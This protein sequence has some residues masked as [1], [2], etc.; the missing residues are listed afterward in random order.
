MITTPVA[1][2]IPE[3]PGAHVA[4]SGTFFVVLAT[5]AKTVAVRIWSGTERASSASRTSSETPVDLP[6]EPLGNARWGR[7]VEGAGPGTLYEFV[8][9]GRALPDPYAR[10][11]PQGVHGPAR[12]VAPTEA[13]A[14]PRILGA[15]EWSIYE[16]HVGTFTPEGTYAAAEKH[17]DHLASLGVSAIELLPVAAFDG[18]RGW[19]YDGVALYAPYAPYGEPDELRAFVKAAHD[20]GLAVVLDVVY[21]HFGPAGNYLGAYAPEYFGAGKQ[22]RW[23]GGPDFSWPG[24]RRL[25]LDNVRYWFD[26]FGF[27]G[28]RLDATHAIHDTSRPHVLREIADLAHMRARRVFFEDDRNDPAIFDGCRADGVWADDFHHQ[29]HVLVTGERDGY[30]ASYEPTVAA[31]AKSIREGWTFSG[32][33]YAAWDGKP[34]GF[35]FG[36]GP[37]ERLV[38]CIQNHDQVGN[39]ACGDRLS[40]SLDESLYLSIVALSLFL[41]TTPLLFMGQEW[42]ARTPFAYFSDH[43][44]ELGK[45]VSKGRRE[46]F[47]SFRA[48]A[49]T[50]EGEEGAATPI[51]IPDPQSEATFLA[52]KLDWTERSEPRAAR[53]LA[54]HRALLLLRREDPVVASATTLD[55]RAEGDVLVVD[56]TRGG[57]LRTLVVNF[58]ATAATLAGLADGEA[59]SSPL[60][61]AG[62]FEPATSGRGAI[63]GPSSAVLTRGVSLVP[64]RSV[65]PPPR[66]A[67]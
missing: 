49:S 38:T 2:P 4:G 67:R 10:F 34:R 37:R 35:P 32:Q 60:F 8:L 28:L 46:E 29:V 65:P 27:D 5:E 25:V 14:L 57:E 48:F 45:N 50:D 9:D 7:Y 11:L 3:T 41:P 33:P 56:R 66:E 64:A 22:T 54:A 20:R 21:N 47:A 31:L 52:S 17:L 59:R 51:A 36:G 16:L 58:G 23:G 30:Y 63:L 19:G 12:V 55:A 6:L 61:V 26:E 62:S 39:R 24:M 13:S 42:G 43:A 18:A 1:I 44:G 53:I 15:R 40:D